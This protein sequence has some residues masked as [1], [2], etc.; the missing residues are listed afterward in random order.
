MMSGVVARARQRGVADDRRRASGRLTRAR[1]A[2]LTRIESDVEGGSTF[3]REHYL[4]AKQRETLERPLQALDV[5]FGIAATSGAAA[6]SPDRRERADRPGGLAA[7]A[8]LDGSLTRLQELVDVD[9]W[10]YRR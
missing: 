1:E 4:T 9:Q 6:G 10:A 2:L 5:P 7:Y 3:A 8:A